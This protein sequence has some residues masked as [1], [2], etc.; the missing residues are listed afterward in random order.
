MHVFFINDSFFLLVPAIL[1]FANVERT[2]NAMM[3]IANGRVAL[4]IF[5]KHS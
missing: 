3:K 5:R 1:W 2:M 4:I